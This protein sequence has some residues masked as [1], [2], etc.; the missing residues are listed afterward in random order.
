M[1]KLKSFNA[2]KILL[3]IRTNLTIMIKLKSLIASLRIH[4]NL[5]IMI[6]ETDEK[7]G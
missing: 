3:R 2:D 1:I 5:T 7:R 6:K 4:M